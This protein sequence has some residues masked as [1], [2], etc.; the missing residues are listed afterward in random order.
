MADIDFTASFL[1]DIKDEDT[2]LADSGESSAEFEG[3]VDTG[4]YALNA[5]ISG[6]IYGG[7]ADTKR[8]IYAALSGVGKTFLIL[9]GVKTFLEKYPGSVVMYYD[10]E[11]AVT[12]QMLIDRGIDPKRVIIIEPSTVEKFRSHALKAAQR[13]LAVPESKRPRMLMALDSLGNLATNKEL[14]DT[15]ADKDTRDMTRAP[16]L[17]GTFRM[18]NNPLA[19]GRIPMLIANHL[20]VDIPNSGKFIAYAMSGGSGARYAAD[21]IIYMTKAI[22]KNQTTKE[23]Y[24]SIVTATA[25]KSR[26]TREKSKVQLKISHSSGLDKY[27]GLVD[28][29]LRGGYFQKLSTKIFIPGVTEE[30]GVFESH[31]Y[32]NPTKYFTKEVLDELDRCAGELFKFGGSLDGTSDTVGEGI[33]PDQEEMLLEE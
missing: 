5:L 23:I 9:T 15:A 13:F 30:K 24:G 3:W 31:I 27:F 29:G 32:K 25:D 2:F 14:E 7:V 20:Y 19:R 10:T 28:I 18:L 11:A 17:K 16:L 1:K 22:D 6:S 33:D 21:T 26:F 12:R 8:V 4:S